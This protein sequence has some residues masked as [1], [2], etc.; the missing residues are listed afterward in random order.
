[1]YNKVTIICNADGY[2]PFF[3]QTALH[4]L[5]SQNNHDGW[6]FVGLAADSTHLLYQFSK[7]EEEPIK[8]TNTVTLKMISLSYN[9]TALTKI[10]NDS[11]RNH[12]NNGYRL[13][14]VTIGCGNIFLVYN[15]IEE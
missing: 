12:E 2:Q 7:E 15:Q 5:Q 8:L 4:S 14:H 1:M 6:N 9:A 10:A 11:I 13:T 3:Q